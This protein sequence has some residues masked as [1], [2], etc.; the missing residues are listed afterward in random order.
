MPDEVLE[1]ART[2]VAPQVRETE[3]MLDQIARERAIAED[4]RARALKE[5]AEA[6]TLKIRARGLLRDAERKHKEVWEPP[7]RTAER[8]LAEL[9]REAHRVRLQLQARARPAV[10]PSRRARRSMRPSRCQVCTRPPPPVVAE[11]EE[12]EPVEAGQRGASVR[13][14]WCRASACLDA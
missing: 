14:S 4:A 9:R 13:T 10:L 6:A 3:A 2:Y 12:P 7:R 1:S 5:A 11:P 8:E